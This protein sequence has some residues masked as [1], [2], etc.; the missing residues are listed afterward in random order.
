[1]VFRWCHYKMKGLKLEVLPERSKMW[2]FIKG[3]TQKWTFP[4]FSVMER[5]QLPWD[6]SCLL[7]WQLV[8]CVGLRD[9]PRLGSRPCW[10]FRVRLLWVGK[11]PFIGLW[12]LTLKPERKILQETS[13]SW[14]SEHQDWE[15]FKSLITHWQGNK[16]FKKKKQKLKPR[17][18]TQMVDFEGC[19]YH[20]GVTWNSAW[21]FFPPKCYQ[22][23]TL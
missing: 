16:D 13:V 14:C 17:A 20:P 6:E 11:A 18:K 9:Q 12:C 23:C 22:C 3:K 15:L 1:M 4:A 19:R 8:F 7:T 10:M 21:D 2:I 5:L